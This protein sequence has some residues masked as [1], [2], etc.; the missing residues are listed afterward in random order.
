MTLLSLVPYL[1]WFEKT[2]EFLLVFLLLREIVHGQYRPRWI[3]LGCSIFL[4]GVKNKPANGWIRPSTVALS[5]I[6]REQYY[7]HNTR[8]FARCR[9]DIKL[10]LF[11]CFQ[12]CGIEV[13]SVRSKTAFHRRL[14]HIRCWRIFTLRLFWHDLMTSACILV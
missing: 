9:K 8:I 6:L 11:L 3:I 1:H 13:G 7:M 10:N 5:A 12:E 4:S 2:M 14:N